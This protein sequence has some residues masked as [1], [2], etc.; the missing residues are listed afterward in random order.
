MKDIPFENIY[1]QK[2][3]L[4]KIYLQDIYISSRY[5][6]SIYNTHI[7]QKKHSVVQKNG[8]IYDLLTYL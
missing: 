6:E 1:L 8:P 4:Q 5:I 2:I 3:Y 7:C